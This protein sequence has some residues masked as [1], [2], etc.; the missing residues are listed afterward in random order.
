MTTSRL[1]AV[2]SAIRHQADDARVQLDKAERF[3]NESAALRVVG[4]SSGDVVHAT[5]D[6]NGQLVDVNFGIELHRTS[7]ADLS[8]AVLEAV[9]QAKRRL[10][11]RVEQLGTEIYGAESPT[12]AM[13]SAAYREQ[14]GYEEI[15]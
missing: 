5:V 11:F 3:S 1:D 12:V 8:A 6:G 15:K 10:S 2:L 13:F 4:A 14:F 9:A 7:S